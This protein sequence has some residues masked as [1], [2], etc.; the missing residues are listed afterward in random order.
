[1]TSRIDA[2]N[3]R[4][5]AKSTQRVSSFSLQNQTL[6]DGAPIYSAAG[7]IGETKYTKIST[8]TRKREPS[9]TEG[10]NSKRTRRSGHDE[11]ATLEGEVFEQGPGTNVQSDVE[12][13]FEDEELLPDI[14]AAV[15]RFKDIFESMKDEHKWKLPGGRY[16]ED[17]VYEKMH[18][19]QDNNDIT[20]TTDDPRRSLP[21]S[22][23]FDVDNPEM[24]A[25]LGEEEKS[26]VYKKAS[27]I[28]KLPTLPKEQRLL[29]EEAKKAITREKVIEL[30]N[31]VRGKDNVLMNSIEIMLTHHIWMCDNQALYSSTNSESWLM[32][33][34][35]QSFLDQPLQ[36]ERMTMQ[37]YNI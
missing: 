7:D 1:M 6:G 9:S 30:R 34:V 12:D 11:M 20:G 26:A 24:M 28:C 10:G 29:C 14:Q 27:K 35:H 22:W 21:Y 33:N 3:Q 37:R 15:D 16:L 32:M 19:N 25:L 5:L 4:A 31:R 8:P 17:I 23:I 2:F 18:T 36:I 13:D